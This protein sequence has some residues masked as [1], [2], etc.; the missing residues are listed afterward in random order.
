MFLSHFTALGSAA[1][2]IADPVR[3]I[4]MTQ[5]MCSVFGWF[6]YL[7]ATKYRSSSRLYIHHSC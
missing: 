3:G 5:T 7:P 2:S 1:A 4:E 6:M